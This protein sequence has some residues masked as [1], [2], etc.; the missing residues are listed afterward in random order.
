[1]SRA[2]SDGAAHTSCAVAAI[3]ERRQPCFLRHKVDLR[4][5][6]TEIVV[7]PYATA[8]TRSEVERLLRDAGLDVPVRDSEL[9]RHAALL[10]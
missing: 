8:D 1:M 6:V 10:P 9:R 7:S 4:P 2:W 3:D 5:L